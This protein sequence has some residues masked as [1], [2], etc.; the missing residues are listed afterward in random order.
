MK[1]D[2]GGFINPICFRGSF[3]LPSETKYLVLGGL[4]CC[5]FTKQ[6]IIE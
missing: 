4:L 6:N 1:P 2:P 3:H 5:I